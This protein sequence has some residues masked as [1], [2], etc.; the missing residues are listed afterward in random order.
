MNIKSI[1]NPLIFGREEVDDRRWVIK[2]TVT[3]STIESNVRISCGN[4]IIITSS[5][6]LKKETRFSLILFINIDG[7][8]SFNKITLGRGQISTKQTRTIAKDLLY[9]LFRK[10]I[11][12]QLVNN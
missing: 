6:G 12:R 4:R 1:V 5:H 8:L 11:E 10:S 9:K 3:N 2:V 7:S